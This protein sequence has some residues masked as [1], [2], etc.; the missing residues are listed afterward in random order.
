MLKIF[1]GTFTS[2]LI[3]ICGVVIFYW[4][5]IGYD[6]NGADLL[7]YLL[8]LPLLICVILLSPLAIYRLIKARQKRKEQQSQAEKEQL[9]QSEAEA[10]Q[11]KPVEIQW[12]NLNIYSSAAY[13]AF[14]E[15]EAIL[16]EL[17]QFK[18][19][20]LDTQLQ[21]AYGLP[22]L[23]YRIQAIDNVITNG[24][25][26]NNFH[27]DRPR[28]LR[29]QALI[30]HQ[31]EQHTESLWHI[32]NHLKQ[33]ALFYDSELAYQYRMHP[34]WIDP[35]HQQDI[36]HS[37]DVQDVQQV[38]KLSRINIHLL[39]P[40]SVLHLW[41]EMQSLE[42]VR[43][44]LEEL[45]IIAQ[46]VHIEHHYLSQE[47][48][49]QAW[50]LLLAQVSEKSEEV[51][52]VLN[53]DSEID[54]E[55]LDEKTWISDH[56][57]PA[58]YASSWC[59]AA[60]SL[61]ILDCKPLKKLKIALNEANIVNQLGSEQMKNLEQFK[62]IQPFLLMLDDITDIQIMKKLNQIFNQSGIESHHFIYTKQS[63]GHTQHL[64]KIFGFMLGMHL[65]EELMGMIYSIDQSSTHSFMHEYEE[66]DVNVEQT[67]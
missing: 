6:P 8:L 50:I 59:I 58:E 28:N 21:N 11:S 5:D 65:P 41:D 43:D 45:G 23:S 52:F 4:R 3:V 24:D 38:P 19:P 27:T 53:V 25:E 44:Y 31:L 39:L 17:K 55:L 2:I 16:D 13:S 40:E 48:A 20:E 1:M 26:E 61:K 29:M 63:L 54:Q 42:I 64:A 9:T 15:N 67:V 62:D 14:G 37:G 66:I 32:A 22:M 10:K 56:Y 47:T 46:Q 35:D 34:A 57:L 30:Q 36:E 51:S 18:G 7:N 60:S 49:Y 12:L 33:S